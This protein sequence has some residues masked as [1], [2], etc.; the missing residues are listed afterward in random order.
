MLIRRVARESLRNALGDS[1]NG[2]N[3]KMV[4]AAA[5]AGVIPFEIQ[6]ISPSKNFLQS[7]VDDEAVTAIGEFPAAALYSVEAIEERGA[8]FRNFS[9]AVQI[10]L[11]FFLRYEEIEGVPTP[12]NR[13]GE[14]EAQYD[15]ESVVDAVFEAVVASIRAQPAKFIQT[16]AYDMRHACDPVQRLSDGYFQRVTF[17]F[18]FTTHK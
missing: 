2:F 8:K 9:G 1:T 7:Y 18:I 4:S 12:F 14:R 5:E 3:A 17:S 15:T 13:I 11:D 16:P 6:W 10:N